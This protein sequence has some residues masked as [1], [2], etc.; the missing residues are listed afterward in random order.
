MAKTHHAIKK[1]KY[2]IYREILVDL[3]IRGGAQ[4]LIIIGI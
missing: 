2:L 3:P 1:V 4:L